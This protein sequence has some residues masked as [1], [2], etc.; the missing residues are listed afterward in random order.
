MYADSFDGADICAKIANAFASVAGTASAPA[1]SARVVLS[2][3]QSYTCSNPLVVPNGYSAPYIY[4]PELDGMNS[5]I[6]Y[7]GSDP[8]GVKVLARNGGP[9]GSGEIVHLALNMATAGS[10]IRWESSTFFTW[11]DVQL[12]FNGSTRGLDMV[13]VNAPAFGG[14]GYF[15]RNRIYLTDI[16]GTADTVA[17]TRRQDPSLAGG[18]SFFYND[19]NFRHVSDEG[20]TIFNQE[21]TSTAFP[22]FDNAS[23]Y[24]IGVNGCGTIFNLA[25]STIMSRGNVILTGENSGCGVSYAVFMHG[26]N[27]LFDETGQQSVTGFGYGFDTGAKESQVQWNGGLVNGLADALPNA[28]LFQAEET[29]NSTNQSLGWVA[30][31]GSYNKVL[32]PNNEGGCSDLLNNVRAAPYFRFQQRKTSFG[33]PVIETNP[34]DTAALLTNVMDFTPICKGMMFGAGYHDDNTPAMYPA[35]N[36][37]IATHSLTLVPYT[38]ASANVV[39]E[40][41]WVDAGS[42][43]LIHY[44]RGFDEA[45]THLD[46]SG[47]VTATG[48]KLTGSCTYSPGAAVTFHVVN[49]A[50]TSCN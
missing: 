34:N 37:D 48:T 13:N 25:D 4:A 47:A 27:S 22:V 42:G 50:I 46:V 43:N 44:I 28:I 5:T 35:G 16:G 12:R 17:V 2:P 19:Y 24:K 20:F 41:G 3:N 23:L 1:A 7:T 10:S 21:A 6:T 32:L 29:N 33:Y 30:L 18:G 8:E 45:E 26:Q 36:P 9:N 49:G 39:H 31:G 38:A 14:G 40:D 11:M 15:E